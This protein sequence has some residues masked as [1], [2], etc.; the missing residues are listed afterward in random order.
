M[1]GILMTPENHLATREG[2]KTATRRLDHL[3]EINKAPNLWKWTGHDQAGR[4]SFRFEPS[5]DVYNYFP[6]YRVGETVYVKEAW[7][8]K[9]DG[10]P[11]SP[12]LDD[13][14]KIC[15]S[16]GEIKTRYG[17]IC[18]SPSGRWLLSVSN[19]YDTGDWQSPMFLSE[20]C[21][22][23]FIKIT[24]TRV[25]RLN[26]IKNHPEDYKAEGYQPIMLDNSAIDGKPFEAS[27]NFAWFENLW[28]T[29]NPKYPYRANPFVWV[30]SY[31]LTENVM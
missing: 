16:D 29:L 1:Q 27:M 12:K 8:I 2:R 30:Y 6:R 5:S 7:A 13:I 17:D 23:T 26:E 9:H 11:F 14:V 15:F 4:F 18:Y 21:A 31:E 28:D 20:L 10:N 24:D 19:A 22:R 25:E 3:K